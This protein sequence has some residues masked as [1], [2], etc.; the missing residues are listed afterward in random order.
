MV[1]PSA[2]SPSYPKRC[3]AMSRSPAI[4]ELLNGQAVK[5]GF[6]STSVTSKRESARRNTRAQVAPPNPPPSTTIRGFACATEGAASPAAAPTAA[7]VRNA[8]RV[9]QITAWRLLLLR[10]PRRDRPDLVI[11]KALR[12]ASHNR[13]WAFSRAKRLHGRCQLCRIAAADRRNGCLHL[14]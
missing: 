1:M 6:G 3:T 2:R 11:R 4:T 10:Q 12:D 13:R 9:V 14:E 5:T 7:P 8:R